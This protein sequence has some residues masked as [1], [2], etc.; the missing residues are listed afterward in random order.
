MEWTAQVASEV[1]DLFAQLAGRHV[2]PLGYFVLA[3]QLGA[4]KKGWIES[5]RSVLASVLAGATTLEM[6]QLT[7]QLIQLDEALA[8]A[9]QAGGT[10]IEDRDQLKIVSLWNSLLQHLPDAYQES[11]HDG[12]RESLIFESVVREA[13][14]VQGKHLARLRAGGIHRLSDL[15]K[16]AP[17]EIASV[18]GIPL[19]ICVR[20]CDSVARYQKELDEMLQ[21]DPWANQLS[22]LSTLVNEL[23]ALQES[24]A[25]AKS[26]SISRS[27]NRASLGQRRNRCSLRMV[28]ILS[29]IGEVDL[30]LRLRRNTSARRIEILKSLLTRFE[31]PNCFS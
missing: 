9:K 18:T 19:P 8:S 4:C 20:V 6:K 10:L 26:A 24:S 23:C 14:G 21:G 16:R 3:L 7:D 17:D 5:C 15:S 2:R 31:T 25:Q 28:R 29:E 1:Q 27:P 13:K 11:S 30:A 12:I 22:R